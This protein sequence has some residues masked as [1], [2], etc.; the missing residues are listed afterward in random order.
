MA[1]EVCSTD[2]S[3][4]AV[5]PGARLASW[6][7]TTP[8]PRSLVFAAAMASWT[9]GFSVALP[10]DFSRSATPSAAEGPLEHPAANATSAVATGTTA[11]RRR[12]RELMRMG[13][14]VGLDSAAVPA[15]GEAP[16]AVLVRVGQQLVI[17]LPLQVFDVAAHEADDSTG[18]VALGKTLRGG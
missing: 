7:A 5:R 16:E 12:G 15:V 11:R 2:W 6:R 14:W 8:T 1:W 13:V 18:V 3:C 4:S 10:R 17:A 9:A